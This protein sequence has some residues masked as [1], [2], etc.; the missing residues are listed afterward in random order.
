MPTVGHGPKSPLEPTAKSP[1]LITVPM[2]T[3]MRF[4]VQS[5]STVVLPPLC[6]SFSSRAT[7]LYAA[8]MKSRFPSPH[9]G[10]L[11]LRP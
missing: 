9:T 8:E 5:S 10:V 3:R 11:M 7:L 2:W 1:S 4:C 6:A